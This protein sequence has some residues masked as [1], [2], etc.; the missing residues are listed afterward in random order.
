MSGQ[1]TRLFHP[2]DFAPEN[3]Y[4]PR[5]LNAHLHPLVRFFRSLD[6]SQLAAR[7]CHLHPEAD[8]ARVETLLKT[9]PTH[10]RWAGA[11]LFHATGR[12]A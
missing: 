11:D 3:H 5:V 4:Y 1:E 2:G 9:A 12:A 10:F 8:P 7:Y 6:N